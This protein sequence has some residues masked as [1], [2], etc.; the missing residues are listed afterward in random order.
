M[1]PLGEV[2]ADAGA[3]AAAAGSA[4]DVEVVEPT[5]E[6]G[7]LLS[8]PAVDVM[9]TLGYR[10]DCALPIDRKVA[11]LRNVGNTCYLNALLRALAAVPRVVLWACEHERVSRTNPRHDKR[12]VLCALARDLRHIR[13][14]GDASPVV[15]E[16]VST[17]ARWSQAQFVDGGRSVFAGHG[18]HDAN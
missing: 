17:R 8:E 13:S 6:G 4:S 1:Q 11:S 9:S 18:Q 3:S 2:G 5:V 7:A 15:P 16:I 14:A 12:C 10:A